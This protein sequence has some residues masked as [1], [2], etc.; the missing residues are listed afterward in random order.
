VESKAQNRTLGDVRSVLRGLRRKPVSSRAE[1][2]RFQLLSHPVVSGG[3]R[4]SR[5]QSTV[6][7]RLGRPKAGDMSVSEWIRST[8]LAATGA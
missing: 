1:L 4:L 6:C 2:S 7:E 5:A 8:S 3:K